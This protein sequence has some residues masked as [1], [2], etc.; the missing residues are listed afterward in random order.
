MIENKKATIRPMTVLKINFNIM[1]TPF[2][3]AVRKGRA[4]LS[5]S[6]FI[7]L[8]EKMYALMCIQ[9]IDICA[10]IHATVCNRGL[11]KSRLFIN[12]LWN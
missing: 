11:K 1:L 10:Y 2:T 3:N 5:L 8:R 6:L 12:L 7:K 9:K 4:F